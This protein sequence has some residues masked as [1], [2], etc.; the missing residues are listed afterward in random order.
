MRGSVTSG[1]T[2]WGGG[3]IGHHLGMAHPSLLDPPIGFAHRG[4][5]ARAQENTLEAFAVAVRL[6]ATGLESDVWLTSDGVPVLDHDGLLRAGLRRRPF[7]RLRRDQLP[8]HVPALAD[9]FDACGT[10]LPLS[11]DVKDPDAFGPVLDAARAAGLPLDR[12]WLCTPDL[13]LAIAWRGEDAAVRLVDSCRLRRMKEGPE[14]RAATLT[15]AGIDAVN[16]PYPDWTA[17]L[18]A[19]FHR[20]GRFAFAW[21]AQHPRQLD[22]LLAMGVDAVYSNHADRLHDALERRRR[23]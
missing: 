19:L 6:G 12:L 20:F 14:R 7:S 8:P 18:V 13:G 9:L 5:S 4:A 1:P 16:M 23:P 10:G 15:E 22:E 2:G 17:G 11:L 21:D 3:T